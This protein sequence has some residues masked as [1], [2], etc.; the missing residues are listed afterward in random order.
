MKGRETLIRIRNGAETGSIE[1][2]QGQESSFRVSL[3]SMAMPHQRLKPQLFQTTPTGRYIHVCT[4]IYLHIP[5]FPSTGIKLPSTLS[6]W[7]CWNHILGWPTTT[8]GAFSSPCIPVQGKEALCNSAGSHWVAARE[9]WPICW[10]LRP[11]WSRALINDLQFL[12]SSTLRH[13]GGEIF[14]TPKCTF[15]KQIMIWLS[16]KHKRKTI[17]AE[18]EQHPISR[19]FCFSMKHYVELNLFIRLIQFFSCLDCSCISFLN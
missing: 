19:G 6:L 12:P 15:Q 11:Q 10:R 5:F 13:R 4:H 2:Y 18:P 17:N 14:P 7:N 9:S 1:Y 8:L 3:A 16:I